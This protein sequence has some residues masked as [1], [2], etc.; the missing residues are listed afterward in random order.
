MLLEHV[1]VLLSI[2]LLDFLAEGTVLVPQDFEPIEEPLEFAKHFIAFLLPE[3]SSYML[4]IVPALLLLGVVI[5]VAVLIV[6]DCH[7]GLSLRQ[8][9]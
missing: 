5:L 6:A 4:L 9:L 1:P 7:L 3:C 8:K 2:H